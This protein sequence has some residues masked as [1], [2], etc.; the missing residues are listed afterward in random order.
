MN[1]NLC[2]VTINRVLIALLCVYH[3]HQIKLKVKFSFDTKHLSCRIIKNLSANA[4][5]IN[6]QRLE[7]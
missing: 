4:Y 3:V 5:L 1:N 6:D 7:S 2:Y